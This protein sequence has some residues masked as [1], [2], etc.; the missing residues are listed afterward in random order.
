MKIANGI[1]RFCEKERDA[2]RE[3]ESDKEGF[4]M[5]KALAQAWRDLKP[6]GQKPYFD[7]YDRNR[8]KYLE[9]VQESKSAEMSFNGG[10]H[11]Q[12]VRAMSAASS[13]V[14]TSN[15]DAAASPAPGSAYDEGE[16]HSM[17][18]SEGGFTAVNR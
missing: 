3:R 16:D 15:Y 8:N 13:V 10:Q 9:K 11:Q 5:H 1:A 17:A 4:D 7:E 18:Q 2:V 6:E 12:P 14:P